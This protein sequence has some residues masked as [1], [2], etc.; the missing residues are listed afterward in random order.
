MAGNP[1]S[2][3][4]RWEDELA[5][6][7]LD[8]PII[9]LTLEACRQPR[10]S[11]PPPPSRGHALWEQIR[12][13]AA[14]GSAA[15][16]E[17]A[18]EENGIFFATLTN[19]PSSFLPTVER[20]MFRGW[21]W[22]ATME[23]RFLI[24]SDQRH[25][26]SLVSKRFRVLEVRD[27]NDRQA[28]L[29]PPITAGDLHMWRAEVNTD[30][31]SPSF[32]TSQPLVGMDSDLTMVGD[33]RQGLG[34]PDSLLVPT[35][36]LIAV[37][38]LHPGV[39]C[40]YEDR[41]GIGLALA[42]WRAEYDTSEYHLAWPCICGSGIMFRPDFLERLIAVAGEHRLILRDFVIGNLELLTSLPTLASNEL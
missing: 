5:S 16:I 20:G 22:L 17:E 37:L 11:L 35:A 10:P 6:T 36:S 34:V 28:F 31:G 2:N 33:G 9:P 29:L 18:T 24:H 30:F 19:K 25:K 15:Y 14:G 23:K 3:P 32:D 7:L 1:V 13:R 40:N 21:Y 38:N 27:V 42:T 12:E 41:D 39:N 8:D 4:I 26:P